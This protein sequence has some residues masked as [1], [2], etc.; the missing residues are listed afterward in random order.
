MLILVFKLTSAVLLPADG[1]LIRLYM[2]LPEEYILVEE[3]LPNDK[4]QNSGPNKSTEF[5]I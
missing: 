3:Q 1:N 2:N 5:R 4:T